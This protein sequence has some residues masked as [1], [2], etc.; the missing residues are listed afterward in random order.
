VKDKR[1]EIG[2]VAAPL[3]PEELVKFIDGERAK[4][5]DG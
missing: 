5:V 4:W 2:A 1:A 3:A